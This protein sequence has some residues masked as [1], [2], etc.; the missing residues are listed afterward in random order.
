M[1]TTTDRVPAAIIPFGQLLARVG[2]HMAPANHAKFAADTI[3][4]RTARPID[5]YSYAGL[6]GGYFRQPWLMCPP[7]VGCCRRRSIQVI[8]EP[9]AKDDGA[10][11]S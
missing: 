11:P 5:V 2:G 1:L 10:A 4:N 7:H 3:S 9:H 8:C 6:L